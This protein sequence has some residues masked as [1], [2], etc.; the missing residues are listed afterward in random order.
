M[1]SSVTGEFPTQRPV[2]RSFGVF[3]EQCLNERLSKQSWGW[4][5][6]MS[7]RPL[8]RHCNE[9]SYTF[10]YIARIFFQ[11]SFWNWQY[12]EADHYFKRQRRTSKFSMI[13]LYQS[14][15]AKFVIVQGT[16]KISIISETTIQYLY[17][18]KP[19]Y[20][21]HLMGYFSAFW[22]SSRWPGAT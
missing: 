22:S 15:S 14:L 2:T 20:N 17:T 5:F 13:V 4:W 8:W 1:T 10:R 12:H 21:D 7:S 19:V 6:E 18:V 9:S 16:S 11:I 3:F